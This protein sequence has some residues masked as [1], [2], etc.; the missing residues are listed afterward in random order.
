MNRIDIL[1]GIADIVVELLLLIIYVPK[2][3]Y[4]ILKD[5]TWVPQFISEELSK[6]QGYQ[7]YVS[8]V[9][10]YILM[11]LAP[12]ALVPIEVIDFAGEDSS[13]W[14]LLENEGTFLRATIFISIPLI[15]AFL[16]ELIKSGKLSRTTLE[17]HFSIQCYL[18]APLILSIQI[19]WALSIIG[20]YSN[21]YNIFYL[22]W[23]DS[24]LLPKLLLPIIFLATFLWLIL[25]QFYLLKKEFNGSKFRAI[26]TILLG[27][28]IVFVVTNSITLKID[29]PSFTSEI[30][31]ASILTIAI[32]VLFGAAL[33][34]RLLNWLKSK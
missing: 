1:K 16:T 13:M 21:P 34:E 25:N 7:E 24:F 19:I 20:N 30:I 33:L 31:V 29:N 14:D 3:L 10:L 15:F 26:I 17:Q 22:Q 12:F 9:F 8:P 11:A 2:T 27:T 28:V 32:V 6:K 4:K 5:P 18:F 23:S